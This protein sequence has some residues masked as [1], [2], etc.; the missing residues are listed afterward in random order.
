MRDLANSGGRR[1]GVYI[2]SVG[3]LSSELLDMRELNGQEV[4]ALRA[5]LALCA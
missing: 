2:L 1:S 5:E 3:A 4:E